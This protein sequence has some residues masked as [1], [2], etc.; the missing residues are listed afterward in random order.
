V[1]GA[2]DGLASFG[3][4]LY[5]FIIGLHLDAG[6]LRLEAR[7]LGI[8]AFGSI[9]VPLLLGVGAGLWMLH[10]VP[11]A[12]GPLGNG[13]VFVAAVAICIAVTALPVL[14]AVLQELGVLGTRLGQTALAIAAVNDAALWVMLAVLPAIARSDGAR[15]LLPLGIAALWFGLLFVVVRPLLARVATAGDQTVLAIGIALALLSASVSEALGTGYL[16]GAF[17]ADAIFPVAC[18]PV[19]LARLELITATVLLPFFFVSTG[20]KALIAPDAPGFLAM[21]GIAIAATVV[22]KLVGTALP[23]R[24]AGF[25]WGESLSLGMMMQTKGL[26]EVVVLAVLRDAGLIGAS[27]FSAM[28]AMAVVCTLLTAPVVRLCWRF[29][30][31]RAAAVSVPREIG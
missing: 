3:V 8:V 22:G 5:V 6:V 31:G 11:D 29:E 4:L 2:V 17:F 10:A 27:I 12:V 14:A 7:R 13:P 24:R 19:L 15:G 30:A 26:M 1:L 18:R 16:V 9:A 23:A 25:S 20:L 28:V 21:L